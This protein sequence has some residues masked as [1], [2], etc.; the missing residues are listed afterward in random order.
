MWMRAL[1]VEPLGSWGLL[2]LGPE[3]R[4]GWTFTECSG[5]WAAGQVIACIFLFG[6]YL[7]TLYGVT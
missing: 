4:P 5:H 3:P 2:S 6:G 1:K 7:M